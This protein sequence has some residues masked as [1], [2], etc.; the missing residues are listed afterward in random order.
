MLHDN[1]G[2][3]LTVKLGAVT[4]LMQLETDTE[5]LRQLLDASKRT[6]MSHRG[7]ARELYVLGQLEASANMAYIL[8]AGKVDYEFEAY[9]QQLAAEAIDRMEAISQADARKGTSRGSK[10]QYF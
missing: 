8:V 5:L 2:L 7:K 4:I 3:A 10:N 9:C 6:A 1:L